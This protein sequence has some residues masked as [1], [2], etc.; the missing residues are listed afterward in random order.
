MKTILKF[1]QVLLLPL[2]IIGCKDT[3]SLPAQ[4]S[5][6]EGQVYSLAYPG[7]VPIGWVPPP[8]EMTCTII[9][10]DSTTKDLRE[11]PTDL[12]GKFWIPLDPGTYYLHVKESTISAESGPLVVKP[13]EVLDVKAYYDNGVR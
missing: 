1:F 6:I 9:I 7:T 4:L 11:L 2:M 3:G 8:L 10:M 12:R 5:G 13:G